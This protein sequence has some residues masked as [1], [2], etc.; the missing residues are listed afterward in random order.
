M[1]ETESV[2]KQFRLTVLKYGLSETDSYILNEYEMYE[3]EIAMEYKGF[4][5]FELG[6]K[7]VRLNT[8]FLVSVEIEEV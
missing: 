8:A 1:V 6:D 5:E 4:F 3:F 7:Q 2:E